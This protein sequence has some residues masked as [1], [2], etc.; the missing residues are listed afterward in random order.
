MTGFEVAVYMSAYVITGVAGQYGAP[1]LCLT[2]QQGAA[3]L[4][5]AAPLIATGAGVRVV[6]PTMSSTSSPPPTPPPTAS[7]TRP[8]S[9]SGTP[10]ASVSGTGTPSGQHLGGLGTPA[11]G[12]SQASGT[13]RAAGAAGRPRLGGDVVL[14]A[15]TAA[16]GGA[17]LAAAV[18]LA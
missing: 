6:P 5:A 18:A 2:P 7:P 11:G 8:P 15:V 14:L 13:A 1:G 9:L 10:S 4:P 16:V 17:L 3:G 12:G